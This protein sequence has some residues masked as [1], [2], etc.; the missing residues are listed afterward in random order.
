ML[1]C[2]LVGVLLYSS[3]DSLSSSAA[4]RVSCGAAT[5]VMG[6]LLIILLLL[7]RSTPYKRQVTAA[8]AVLGT[9]GMAALR[10][11]TG[12][13]LPSIE[14]L[15]HNQ[16]VAGYVLAS[17]AI[18]AAITLRL[19]SLVLVYHGTWTFFPLSAAIIS[20]LLASSFSPELAE[21]VTQAVSPFVTPF[22]TPFATPL[23]TPLMAK[24]KSALPIVRRS[25]PR[26]APEFSFTQ[27]RQQLLGVA[28]SHTY[29][30]GTPGSLTNESPTG[31]PFHLKVPAP[32]PPAKPWPFDAAPD[33]KS[34]E[35]KMEEHK[36]KL[37]QRSTDAANAGALVRASDGVHS[38]ADD[39]MDVSHPPSP[40]ASDRIKNVASGRMIK[41]GGPLYNKLVREGHI[42]DM[43]RGILSPPVSPEPQVQG[44][45]LSHD[46]S[47]NLVFNSDEILPLFS[48]VAYTRKKGAS[49]MTR[50]QKGDTFVVPWWYQCRTRLPAAQSIVM[51]TGIDASVV[52]LYMGVDTG[53][54]VTLQAWYFN[55]SVRMVLPG[56]AGLLWEYPGSLT[57][58]H[59][60]PGWDDSDPEPGV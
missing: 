49:S 57:G 19:L 6:S 21:T 24:T 59:R 25:P 17:A 48:P 14:Q 27:L 22:V 2:L 13:W 11:A 56:C 5:F 51:Y 1:A 43:G 16:Y 47:Q 37:K 36:G 58:N 54:D 26:S 29:E 40:G 4:F 18:G 42:S 52:G 3:S 28:A 10:W 12:Q 55:I 50:T 31:S 32:E 20:L 23:A 9:S 34:F 15:I 7:I 53:G 30:V 39:P 44:T 35:E 41:I 45:S 38:G 33:V 8:A 46:E 60:S